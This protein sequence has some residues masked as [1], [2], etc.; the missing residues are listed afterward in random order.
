MSLAPPARFYDYMIYYECGQ[1]EKANP[2]AWKNIGSLPA[3]SLLNAVN[4]NAA[5]IDVGDGAGKTKVGVTP[6]AIQAYRKWSGNNSFSLRNAND[7]I[8][9]A[10]Y[11]WKQA[12]ADQAANQACACLICQGKWAG[13]SSTSLSNTCNELRNKCDKKDEATKIKGSGYEALAKLTH[14]FSNPMDA[15]LIIRSFRL[16]YLRSCKNAQK[17]AN[18]WVRRE[19]IP[20]ANEC[21]CCEPGLPELSKLG[22]TPIPKIETILSSIMGKNPQLIKLMDWDSAPSDDFSLGDISDGSDGVLPASNNVFSN[23]GGGSNNIGHGSIIDG[24][25][26]SYGLNKNNTQKGMIVGLTLNQK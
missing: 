15:Y 7:W 13:W 17:F 24:G 19:F 23:L 22:F 12:C 14:C 10:N 25:T 5:A 8:Q 1:S 16:A 11:F 18:G 26:F 3:G 6:I 2:S 4:W 21:L 20:F 9:I